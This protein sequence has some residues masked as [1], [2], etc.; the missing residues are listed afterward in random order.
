MT[1]VASKDG[2]DQWWKWANKPLESPLTI[3]AEIHDAV[4]TLTEEER[5]DRATVNEAVRTRGS[6]RRPAGSAD[7]GGIGQS[8]Q[9]RPES[10]HGRDT[11]TS[12]Q[13]DLVAC[14]RALAPCLRRCRFEDQ[15]PVFSSSWNPAPGPYRS[16]APGSFCRARFLDL[17]FSWRPPHI[18]KAPANRGHEYQT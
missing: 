4:M 15:C 17:I 5:M 10:G 11:A 18:K 9:D 6:P 2:F 1:E 14:V 12:F 7:G 3:P 13:Q 8:G 16:A